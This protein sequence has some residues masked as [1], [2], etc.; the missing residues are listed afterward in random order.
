MGTSLPADRVDA[1]ATEVHDCV[2]D[3]TKLMD[4]E[5]RLQEQAARVIRTTAGAVDGGGAAS[6][7]RRDQQR[8]DMSG[9][10]PNVEL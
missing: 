6:Q 4:K 1:L 8:L 5:A 10:G 9:V 3:V 7:F 2:A